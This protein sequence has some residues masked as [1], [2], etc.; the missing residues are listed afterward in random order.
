MGCAHV[1]TPGCC[2]VGK[3]RQQRR[4]RIDSLKRADVALLRQCVLPGRLRTLPQRHAAP[5][6]CSQ[7]VTSA[8]CA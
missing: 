1:K 7:A 5:L 4:E 3:A 8:R 2:V 6:A